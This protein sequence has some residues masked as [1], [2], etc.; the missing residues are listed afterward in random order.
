MTCPHANRDV[1]MDMNLFC[2]DCGEE[3]GDVFAQNPPKPKKSFDIK[4]FYDGVLRE[5]EECGADLKMIDSCVVCVGCGKEFANRMDYCGEEY[6]TTVRCGKPNASNPHST[7]GGVMKSSALSKI[8]V[9]NAEGVMVTRDLAKT[10]MICNANSKEKSFYKVI[11]TLDA[12]TLDG[13]FNERTVNL[14]KV[15][16]REID[17][18]NRIFRG[19]NRTGILACCVI[20]A[21]HQCGIPVDREIVAGSF[22]VS[23]DD[24]V[25]GEPIFCSIIRD[26]KL[27]GILDYKPDLN[28]QFMKLAMDLETVPLEK[29]RECVQVFK[30]CGDFITEIHMS[31]AMGSI[32]LHVYPE[33]GA[34]AVSEAVGIRKSTLKSTVRKIVKE[35]A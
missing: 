2:T 33:I 13:N 24:L 29:V 16:W 5:C 1:N 18:T 15:Y 6:D 22:G 25:K 21:C 26:T 32:L 27:K 28:N 30:D 14:A 19:G 7:L 12:L 34:D 23:T 4:G 35:L 11:T 20:Y 9:K 31:T 3:I 10:N 8:K 17:R